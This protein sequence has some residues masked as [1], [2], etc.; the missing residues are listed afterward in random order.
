MAKDNVQT[1]SVDKVFLDEAN[2][3][4]EPC[5]N[6]ED[7][8][9]AL[10]KDE[11]VINLAIDIAQHGLNPHE[12]FALVKKPSSDGKSDTYLVAEGNRRM[13]AIKLLMDPDLA[14]AKHRDEIEK[15]A[16]TAKIPKEIPAI[17]YKSKAD[18]DLWLMRMH[19][20]PQNG[21]GRKPW[22][23][24]QK[25]R[26][27]GSPK[28]SLAMKVLDYAENKGFISKDERKQKLT[29]AQRFLSNVTFREAIGLEPN[30]PDGISRNRS[31]AEFDTLIRRFT[32]D[33]A[34]K[35]IDSR[36]NK[37][38]ITDYARRLLE[39][40]DISGN[41]CQP[42]PINQASGKK[43]QSVNKE[44]DGKPSKPKQKTKLPYSQEVYEAIRQIPSYKLEHI[45][46]SL[47][48][49][50]LTDHT[51]LLAVG[52]WTFIETLTALCGRN[53][54]NSFPSFLNANKLE[55]LGLGS[56]KVTKP[57]IEII[58]R[59]SEYGNTTKHHDGAAQFDS[60]QLYNDF[61][62]LE[63]MIIALAHDAKK[64]VSS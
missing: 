62:N 21:V 58:N 39:A 31:Q 5:S 16:D 29:T 37:T 64:K 51:P 17:V 2:F 56:K 59:V 41:R 30:H 7:A 35:N 32:Y 19:Q 9:E 34:N 44:K 12:I 14:P 25:H 3:R 52:L 1:I 40:P 57:I 18:F 24:D 28:N 23:A 61:E 36:H 11:Q 54:Q 60:N 49:I 33:L 47:C 43:S 46:Y 27:S 45:Y 22:N 4:H 15:H 13:C 48:Q 8:M 42:E 38:E 20:G 26:H 10:I 63:K 50:K 6:Q 55:A 53:Q